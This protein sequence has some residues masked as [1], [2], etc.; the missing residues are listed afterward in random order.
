MNECASVEIAASRKTDAKKQKTT[1]P[2]FAR[3]DRFWGERS[4]G[5]RKGRE[6]AQAR[7][8]DCKARDELFAEPVH[9]RGVCC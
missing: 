9:I 6:A 4:S 5:K 8:D 3:S 2:G 7:F 1:T